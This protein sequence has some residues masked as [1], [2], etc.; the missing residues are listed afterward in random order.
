V[1]STETADHVDD[2]LGCTNCI[3]A[4]TY[5]ADNLAG[6]LD[7]DAAASRPVEPLHDKHVFAVL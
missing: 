6:I 7:L 4:L 5:S 1:I 2:R 3:F